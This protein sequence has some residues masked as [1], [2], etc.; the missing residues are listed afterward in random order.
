M[1]SAP[2]FL[3][4]LSTKTGVSL[5][6]KSCTAGI[7]TTEPWLCPSNLALRSIDCIWFRVNAHLPHQKHVQCWRELVP[8]NVS[9]PVVERWLWGARKNIGRCSRSG[10]R[11]VTRFRSDRGFHR[12]ELAKFESIC[13]P[14]TP[15]KHVFLVKRLRLFLLVI[16]AMH[17]VQANVAMHAC[18][19]STLKNYGF[20]MTLASEPRPY[21]AIFARIWPYLPVYGHICMNNFL[22]HPESAA[23]IRSVTGFFD[24]WPQK[25]VLYLAIM[26]KKTWDFGLPGEGTAKFSHFPQ[27]T[28]GVRCHGMHPVGCLKIIFCLK[29]CF[30]FMMSPC[31]WV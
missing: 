14:G 4:H 25:T 31:I 18:F 28:L 17:F 1:P 26:T 10:Q 16:A 6:R 2:I 12:F 20:A 21:M 3:Y 22:G 19:F 23:S 5:D 9:L 13:L 27:N 29:I 11:C 8:G 15:K 7:D 30:T 24:Q